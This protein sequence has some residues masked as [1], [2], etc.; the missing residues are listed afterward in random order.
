ML[1][2]MEYSTA[3]VNIRVKTNRSFL[4]YC[5]DEKD[6]IKEPVHQRIKPVKGEVDNVE[7]LTT[8]EFRKLI[9]SMDESR[10]VG[11]R[12]KVTTF[13]LLDTLRLLL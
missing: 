8:E 11:F 5:Y 13:V 2:E 4:R 10:Y 1:E 7:L 6:W 9:G 12:S 3:T